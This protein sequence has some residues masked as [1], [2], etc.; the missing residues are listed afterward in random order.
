MFQ[1]LLPQ[2]LFI[3]KQRQSNYEITSSVIFMQVHRLYVCMATH[4]YRV[5]VFV[6]GAPFFVKGAPF[7][8]KDYII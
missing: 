7:D 1:G 3:E 5:P 2:A 6:K 4:M 8:S